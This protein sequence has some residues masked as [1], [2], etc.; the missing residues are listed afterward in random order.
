MDK[1]TRF[2]NVYANLPLPLR[3]EVIYVLPDKEPKEPM[4]WNA[5]FIEVQYNTP[6]GEKLLDRLDELGFI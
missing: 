1:K 2:L 3:N 5:V 6:L 4:S